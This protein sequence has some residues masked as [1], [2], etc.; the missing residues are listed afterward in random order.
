MKPIPRLRFHPTHILNRRQRFV[1]PNNI[2]QRRGNP[3]GCPIARVARFRRRPMICVAYP[4]GMNQIRILRRINDDD[5]VNVIRHHNEHV[6]LNGGESLVK[7]L[8]HRTRH[9]PCIIQSHATIHNI[10]EQTQPTM[11][12]DGH[13]IRSGERIIIPRQTNRP[14]TCLSIVPPRHQTPSARRA[15]ESPSQPSAL[16]NI[17]LPKLISNHQKSTCCPEFLHKQ[18]HPM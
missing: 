12:N 14:T 7:C 9:L 17:S 18:H 4:S 15:H 6:H 2:T 8:P 10:T 3:C 1:C 13:E 11:H 5:A 16:A